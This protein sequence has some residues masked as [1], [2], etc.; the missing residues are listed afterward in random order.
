MQ[1]LIAKGV[2]PCATNKR[3]VQLHI[4]VELLARGTTSYAISFASFLHR[5]LP[6]ANA[7]DLK[8]PSKQMAMMGVSAKCDAAQKK[9]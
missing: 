1:I 6:F 7:N 8:N 9:K 3:G 5:R 2:H 4:S